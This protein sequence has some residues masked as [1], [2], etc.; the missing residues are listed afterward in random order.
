MKTF[1]LI[2]SLIFTSYG[3]SAQQGILTASARKDS[4][5]V[6]IGDMRATE[7]VESAGVARKFAMN[8]LK[9]NLDD[10]DKNNKNNI[11]ADA[12]S[13]TERN[14]NSEIFATYLSRL[15]KKYKGDVRSIETDNIRDIFQIEQKSEIK[16]RHSSVVSAQCL[17]NKND[18][19]FIK[20]KD[21]DGEEKSSAIHSNL[22]KEIHDM[23]W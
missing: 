10:L 22:S 13:N 17:S 2:S 3:L 23:V 7:Q 19:K 5:G 4:T 8:N 1:S 21:L 12:G 15:D 16:K 20:L 14:L 11:L 6:F 9:K 18:G